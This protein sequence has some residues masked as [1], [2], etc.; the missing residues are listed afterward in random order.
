MLDGLVQGRE[1][2]DRTVTCREQ[3]VLN[4]LVLKMSCNDNKE[5]PNHVAYR[6]FIPLI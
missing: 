3:S 6:T 4:S 5:F 2:Q 1:P